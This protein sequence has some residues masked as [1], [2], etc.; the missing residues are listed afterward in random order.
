MCHSRKKLVSVNAGSGSP[1]QLHAQIV[2]VQLPCQMNK[3]V[4][5]KIILLLFL[6]DEEEQKPKIKE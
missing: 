6:A 5:L 2:L 3:I 4:L 1:V